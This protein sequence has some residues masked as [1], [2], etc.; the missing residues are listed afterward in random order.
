MTMELDRRLNECA[1]NLNDGGMLARLT[2]GEIVAQ[3]LK[4]HRSCLTALQN[5]ERTHIETIAQESKDKS[6]EKEIYPLVF[7]ELLA[8][9]VETK[10][11]TDGPIVFKLVDLVS[12]YKQRPSQFGIGSTDSDIHSTRLKDKVLANIHE[13]EAHKCGRDIHWL[14]RKM[15]ALLCHKLL[16]IM[17]PPSLEKQPRYCEGI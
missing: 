8:F 11:N 7:S 3:E 5:R 9:I 14:S 4:S 16:T 10:L 12:L 17:K 6:R 13:L 2:G 1:R 15:L